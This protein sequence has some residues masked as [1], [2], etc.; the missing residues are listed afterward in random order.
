[1]HSASE[2]S[3]MRAEKGIDLAPKEPGVSGFDYFSEVVGDE[4]LL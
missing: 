3:R 2:L 4:I 1:M